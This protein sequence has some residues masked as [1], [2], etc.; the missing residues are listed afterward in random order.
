MSAA[1]AHLLEEIMLLP[2]DDRAD[3]VEAILERSR[4]TDDFLQ[5]QAEVVARRMANVKA[6][7]SPLIPAE[8][9]HRQVLA[10]LKPRP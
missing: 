6:G 9:A 2:N 3:L 5:Q 1:V 4:P 10:S 7:V 8:E